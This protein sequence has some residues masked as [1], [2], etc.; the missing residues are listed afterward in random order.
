M[1][2]C[3]KD[4]TMAMLKTAIQMDL[5][6]WITQTVRLI[7]GS[8]KR[9][10]GK[11]KVCILVATILFMVFGKKEKFAEMSF[12]AHQNYILKELL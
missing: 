6:K 8:G 3:R 2:S 12:I 5:A 7:K 4:I 11:V 1:Y 10:F 9:D